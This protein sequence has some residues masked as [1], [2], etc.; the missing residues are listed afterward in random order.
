MITGLGASLESGRTVR[1][2]LDRAAASRRSAS[3][4]PGSA[5]RP[6]TAGRGGC[7]GVARTVERLLDALGHDQV[8]V[9]GVS[10]GG[11][12]AQQLA[13]QA[14][15][16]GAPARAGRHRARRSAGVPGSP[17]GAAGAGHPRRYTQPDYYRR[18][19]GDLYGGAARTDPDA[20]LHGS[21]ARFSQP[22]SAARLPR[23]ALRD[24]L[25]GPSCRGCAGSGSRRSCSPATT[26]R[27]SRRQ[28]PDPG[29]LHPGRP[30]ARRPRRRPPVPARTPGG[31]GDTS[32]I[33]S[34]AA[35]E[36]SR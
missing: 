35:G 24:Q 16:P 6:A 32:R 3:T 1:T 14:P 11:V 10:L 4:H 8:D 5:S 29:P 20:L 26:T 31:D 23:P 36:R 18:V 21:L 15:E 25:A 2:G 34:S 17:R 9:L 19:A 27:S 12:L 33:S 28:R 22:P 13:H 30:A 7:A